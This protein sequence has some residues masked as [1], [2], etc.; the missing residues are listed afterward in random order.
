MVVLSGFLPPPSPAASA[1]AIRQYYVGNLTGI[2]IGMV[3]GAIGT[4][5]F[6]S[7]GAV[8]VEQMRRAEAPSAF[9]SRL[10]MG[11]LVIVVA[12]AE[13]FF[14]V[15]VTAAFRPAD[16]SPDVTRMLND[17]GWVL[18]LV[19]LPPFDAFVIAL[20]VVILADR[21]R[22]PVFPR[23]FGYLNIWVAVL[24]WPVMLMVFFKTGPFDYRGAVTLYLPMA[25]LGV[26][27]VATTWALLKAI[28]DQGDVEDPG[29]ERELP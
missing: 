26:W 12:L 8:I 25:A 11:L 15:W 9:I 5:G 21:R 29:S 27:L 17:F 22:D 20:S 1:A 28:A 2:R 4:V 18:F 3:V 7:F 6:L 10:S 14:L 19:A 16:I 24:Q 23:W 13:M